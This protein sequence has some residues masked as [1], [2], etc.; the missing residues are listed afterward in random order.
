MT[1]TDP[2]PVP[3]PVTPSPSPASDD[4]LTLRNVEV[5]YNEISLAVRGVSL[6]VPKNSVIALL[7]ANGAGKTTTIR[8]I[9]GLLVDPRRPRPRG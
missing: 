2:N 6:T 8:A 9:T 5:V 3:N 4:I 7:G 1:T